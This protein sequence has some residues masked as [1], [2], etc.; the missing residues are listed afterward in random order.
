MGSI[1]VTK[2]L[3]RRESN[4]GQLG[5][6]CKRNLSAIPPPLIVR[7]M[8][9]YACPGQGSELCGLPIR[10]AP[11]PLEVHQRY[12]EDLQPRDRREGGFLVHRLRGPRKD[13]GHMVGVNSNQTLYSN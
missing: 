11:G 8:K 4:L 3:Q 6:K 13:I 1:D 10:T 5:D 2:L 12:L 9:M 7:L